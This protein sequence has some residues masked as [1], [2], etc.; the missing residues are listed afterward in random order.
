MA[1][2]R[3][4]TWPSHTVLDGTEVLAVDHS[5]TNKS[6]TTSAVSNF[7]AENL[8][9]TTA[10]ILESNTAAQN[11]AAIET[12][13]TSL[14]AKKGVIN[15]PA[16]KFDLEGVSLPDGV[17]IYGQGIGDGV[18]TGT[19]LS[20][21]N[22]PSA[23]MFKT[24]QSDV[25]GNFQGGGFLN[26]KALGDQTPY[27]AEFTVDT[28]GNKLNATSHTLSN[29]DIIHLTSPL[30]LS[31]DLAEKT[32]YYV[33]NAAPNDFQVATSQGGSAIPLS[34]IGNGKQYF[35]R[36][37][38]IYDFYDLSDFVGA[39]SEVRIESFRFDFCHIEGFR[40]AVGNV[41]E[42]NELRDR[43][44]QYVGNRFV[45]NVAA[46][47][48]NE[49]PRFTGRNDIRG[50]IFGI[51]GNI[52]DVAINSQTFVRNTFDVW[53]LGSSSTSMGRSTFTGNLVIFPVNGIKVTSNHFSISGANIFAAALPSSDTATE[54]FIVLGENSSDGSVTGGNVFEEKSS[55]QKCVNACIV[56]D[57]RADRE[58]YQ[59]C[60]NTF[61][62]YG[63]AIEFPTGLATISNLCCD[64]NQFRVY[65]GGILIRFDDDLV[66]QQRF[67][68]FSGNSVRVITY[69]DS[70][71]VLLD[72]ESRSSR[73][74]KINDNLWRV[75]GTLG[76]VVSG[77][78]Q[79]C[80]YVGNMH[81][82]A[83][84]RMENATSTTVPVATRSGFPLVTSALTDGALL[85]SLNVFYV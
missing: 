74:F 69:N 55:T 41:S 8:G 40:Y 48:T 12:A 35:Y 66:G 10:S 26:F 14:G 24:E 59:I 7:V 61:T 20:L 73:G 11:A 42:L 81:Y 80:T 63:K 9:S 71:A 1:T 38:G 49:H 58:R 18:Q 85:K 36:V 62:I 43:E 16:G 56:V 21:P 65:D 28:S 23:P 76:Y 31:T 83:S 46:I 51:C 78:F 54:Q 6:V 27:Y 29:N 47:Y 84:V 4:T 64:N 30:L 2:S 45:G 57:D 75:T 52:F 3:I 19:T 25:V 79:G 5:N 37:S 34:N 44:T 53:P 39:P 68:S 13:I 60:S 22:S 72:L 82:N 32:D 77:E 70:N 15:L 67:C 50:N 33:V 17:Y